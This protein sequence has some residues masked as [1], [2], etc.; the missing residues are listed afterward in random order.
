MPT[1]SRSYRD[2][3]YGFASLR[4]F[5]YDFTYFFKR[6]STSSIVRLDHRCDG[7][8]RKVWGHAGDDLAGLV[9]GEKLE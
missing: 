4:I 9:D 1:I 5:V 2:L 3:I 6:S 8:Y 7:A